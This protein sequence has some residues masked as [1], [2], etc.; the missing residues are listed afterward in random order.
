MTAQQRA[1]SMINSLRLLN[2]FTMDKPEWTLNDLTEELDIGLSA[3]YRI[4]NTL[5][6]EFFLIKDPFTTS[7]RLG[8]IILPIG[9][10]IISSY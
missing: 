2:L 9:H 5:I 3:V 8:S 4:T 10:S 6:H 1:S 7:L